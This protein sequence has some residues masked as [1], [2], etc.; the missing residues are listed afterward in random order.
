MGTIVVLLNI[1]WLPH[2]EIVLIRILELDIP[3]EES[4]SFDHGSKWKP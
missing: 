3:K 2:G 1:T 4:T